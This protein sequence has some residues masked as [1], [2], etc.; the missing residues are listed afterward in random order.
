MA[1]DL[2]LLRKHNITHIL[3][4][5]QIVENKYV[6]KFVYKKLDLLDLPETKITDHFHDCFQFIDKGK[7]LFL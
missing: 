7:F 1:V 5:A 6:G 3:N 2:E 4:L